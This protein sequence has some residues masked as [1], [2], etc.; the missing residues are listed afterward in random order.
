M[1]IDAKHT[2]DNKIE[3]QYSISFLA[4]LILNQIQFYALFHIAF[5]YILRY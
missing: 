5:T 1:L 3:R 4:N 2:P